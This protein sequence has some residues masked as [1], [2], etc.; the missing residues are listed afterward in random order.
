MFFLHEYKQQQNAKWIQ[1][2]IRNTQTTSS[3]KE[4]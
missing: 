4:H 3:I 1:Q 2:L